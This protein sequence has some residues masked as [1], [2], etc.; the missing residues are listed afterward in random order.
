MQ[1]QL[2]AP[3]ASAF[4][5]VHKCLRLNVKQLLDKCGADITKTVSSM[6]LQST[7][8]KYDHQRTHRF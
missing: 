1:A 7:Q 8:I 5:A 2:V 6:R 4:E 3:D